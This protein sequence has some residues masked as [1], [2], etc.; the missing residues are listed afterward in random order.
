MEGLAKKNLIKSNFE[1]GSSDG[2]T[3]AESDQLQFG[4]EFL[5]SLTS[6]YKILAPVEIKKAFRIQT[7]PAIYL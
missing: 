2:I 5:F 1:Y 6:F 3:M 4:D 7:L